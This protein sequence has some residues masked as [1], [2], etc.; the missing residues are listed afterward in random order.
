MYAVSSGNELWIAI[1]S[2][3][4]IVGAAALP[5]WLNARKTKHAIGTP[6]GKGTVV[7]MNEQQLELLGAIREGQAVTREHLRLID[8]KIDAHSEL[9]TRRF[10]ALHDH[11][12]IP[13]EETT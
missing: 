7:E 8:S 10:R 6:N 1:I 9:D 12:N 13:F 4:A 5:A 2:G 3:A 11:L